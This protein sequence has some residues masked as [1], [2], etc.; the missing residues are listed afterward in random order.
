MIDKMVV[1]RVRVMSTKH[2][3]F[4]TRCQLVNST[5]TSIPVYW[6]QL[7]II[8]H[9]V[10]KEGNNIYRCNLW[11]GT[12]NDTKPSDINWESFVSHLVALD[13]AIHGSGI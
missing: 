2:L 3:S 13:P 1:S 8:P 9:S 4:A 7:F 11:S 12:H 6:G 10:L 5:L